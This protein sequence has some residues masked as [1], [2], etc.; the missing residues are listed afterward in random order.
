MNLKGNF[1]ESRFF[2]VMVRGIAKQIIFE[3][4]DDNRYYLYLLKIF[5]KNYNVKILSYCLMYNH[6]HILCQDPE[7]NISYMMQNL[8]CKYAKYF[9]KKYDRVGPLFQ[10]PFKKKN[11][12]NDSYLLQVFRYIIKNPE[13]DKI[14]PYN[15]YQWSN[16]KFLWN[17]NHFTDA[18]F[19]L[20]MLGKQ[21][22][23]SFLRAESDEENQNLF[24]EYKEGRFTDYQATKIIKDYY[25]IKSAS[26]IRTFDKNERDEA[27]IFL[28]SKGLSL[29]QIERLTGVSRGIS[30][31]ILYDSTFPVLS[32]DKK[33]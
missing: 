8:C 15:L 21:D 20:D 31:H 17:I 10:K 6:A 5:S 24:L 33:G 9:N 4:N 23:D 13:N 11:I 14:C 3:D 30:Q 22:V 18:T 2:H 26:V 19:I 25:N 7:S 29:R 28:R 16:Y 32:R 12:K 27:I 1:E